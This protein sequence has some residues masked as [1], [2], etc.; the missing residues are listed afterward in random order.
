MVDRPRKHEGL[1][2]GNLKRMGMMGK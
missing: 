2:K 1:A